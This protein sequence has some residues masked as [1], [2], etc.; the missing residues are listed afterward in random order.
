MNRIAIAL[1]ASAAALAATTARADTRVSVGVNVG[2]PVYRPAPAVVYAPPPVVAYNPAPVVVAPAPRGYWKE[3]TVKTWI[4]ERVVINRNRWGREVRVVEPGYYTYRT[5]RVWV[6]DRHDNGR[7][8]GHDRR[9]Y[10]YGYDHNRG[11]WNR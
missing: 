9:D 7:H 11:G 1:L 4:P 3:V 6:D 5:D 2:A 10:S 8:Y